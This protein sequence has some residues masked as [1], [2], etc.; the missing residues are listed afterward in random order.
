[1]ADVAE[2]GHVGVA[3]SLGASFGGRQRDIAL[4]NF[5]KFP[6]GFKTT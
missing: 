4:G 2:A 6:K 5:S 3:S 1:M